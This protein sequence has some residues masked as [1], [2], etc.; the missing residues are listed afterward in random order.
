MAA[1]VAACLLAAGCK[2]EA[3]PSADVWATVNGQQVHR[4][5]VQKYYN[6][7]MNPQ[8]PPGSQDEALSLTLNILDELINNDILI[9]RAAKQGLTA[10]DGE[11]EDKFTELKSPFTEDEFQRQM[12]DHKVSVDDIKQDIR[13]QLSVQKLMNREV[14]AKITV[15]DRDIADFYAQ[16]RS[17]FNVTE[18]NYHMAQIMVTP[19]KDPQVRNRKND[20][21]TTDGEARKKIAA[22]LQKIQ[23][24]AD[25]NA[26][27]MDYS[28][29][30][31]TA[32]SGGDLGF[33]PESAL[34][35]SDP[36]LKKA[37]LGMKPGDVSGVIQLKDSYRILKLVAKET[38]GQ[39]D[40]ADPQVQQSIRD[41]I[42]NRKEQL[43]RAAY[44]ASA[45]NDAR[46]KN[47]L[48]EQVT[49]SAGKLPDVMNLTPPAPAAAAQPG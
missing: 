28:E 49:E 26:L 42:R 4:A 22:L 34:S 16:N 15:T 31:Q 11:V 5:E 40:L 14:V 17:Q 35:Q 1:A 39:R 47:Y 12:R 46:V 21:A 10:T 48:A 30:P 43:L 23:T 25:F 2:H 3:A 36:A 37:V 6:S 29:D 19:Q 7:R 27:A 13:Q 9:Q 45:R 20:D 41:T 44:L 33:V 38:P 18:T 32:A 8:Q 24:G